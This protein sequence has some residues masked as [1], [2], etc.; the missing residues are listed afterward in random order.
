[1]LLLTLACHPDATKDPQST[2]L[3]WEDAITLDAD[4][5]VP[6]DTTLTISPGVVVT[7]APDVAL[8]VQGTLIAQGTPEAPVVFTGDAAAPWRSLVFEE[9][10]VDAQFEGV[11]IYTGA[12]I[13]ENAVVEHA[14]RGMELAGSS[15]YLHAIRFSNNE[16]P[17]GVDTIGGAALLIR[18]GASPRVRDCSFEGNIANLFAFGGA[19]YVDHADPILQDNVF[20]ENA[21]SYG[22]AISTNMM[23]SP[24]VGSSF[25]GNDSLSEGGAISLVS[26]VSAV[27]ANTVTNNHAKTDGAG[28]HVCVT[29]D[30]H[31]APYLLDNI[32]TGNQSDNTDPDEGAAGVGAA[33]LGIMQSNEIH[34]N[35]RDGVPSDFGWFNP[36]SEG[37]PDWIAVPVLSDTWWGTT[38]LNEINSHIWDGSD[39][40]SQSTV[41]VDPIRTTSLSGALPR[42]VVAS[43]RFQY[44]DAGDEVPVFLTLYNPGAAITA[45]LSLSRDG[46]P[47][48]GVLDYPGA[49]QEGDGWTIDMP[50]N[51]VWFATLDS[52][53]YDGTTVDDTLWE[54]TLF[55]NGSLVGVPSIARYLY[56]PVSQ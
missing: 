56:T 21:A 49:T 13:V 7:L 14:I 48:E 25:D 35:L 36:V 12:S 44:Q 2:E 3:R 28:I 54:A 17:S 33:Y 29:C 18:D 50:E 37:W 23:A 4:F 52:S 6:P 55:E 34:D 16:Y 39:S 20:V 46:L 47:F 42:V 26:T 15:P 10:A 24:I 1:M 30:P 32:V 31:A 38:D 5:T 45:T 11:D 53:T 41:V 40:D 9:S 51:S 19:I 8:L 22:G 43:R 27:L